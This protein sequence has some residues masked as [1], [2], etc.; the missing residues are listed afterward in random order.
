MVGIS[1]WGNAVY[2]SG[3]GSHVRAVRG[4]METRGDL[5]ALP[6]WL[7]R[8]LGKLGSI[9][10]FSLFAGLWCPESENIGDFSIGV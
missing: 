6:S 4:D 5:F 10:I 9:G 2:D 3:K 8:K 1:G 7:V